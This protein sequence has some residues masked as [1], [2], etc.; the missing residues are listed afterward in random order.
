MHAPR[1]PAFNST[2]RFFDPNGPLPIFLRY[3]TEGSWNRR[4]F[5]LEPVIV[6]VN[7]PYQVE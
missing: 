5:H 4:C 2:A 3:F 1:I 6:S 7:C